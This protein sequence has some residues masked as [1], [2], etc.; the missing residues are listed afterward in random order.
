M[1][2]KSEAIHTHFFCAIRAFIQLELMRASE[3]IEN[4]YQVQKTLYLKVAREFILE[5]LKQKIELVTHNQL[6]VNA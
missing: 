1:V 5:H 4:W 2:R 6:P 3:L